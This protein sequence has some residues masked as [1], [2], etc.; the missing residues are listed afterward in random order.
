MDFEKMLDFKGAGKWTLLAATYFLLS[1]GFLF[2]RW[3]FYYG[4]LYAVAFASIAIVL[5]DP[6]PRLIESLCAAAAG[7]LSVI[8]SGYANVEAVQGMLVL[9]FILFAFMFMDD[10]MMLTKPSRN[11]KY[12]A[13]AAMLA[14]GFWAFDYFRLRLTSGAPLPLATILNHGGVML[15]SLNEA[16]KMAGAKYEYQEEVS[17]VS[18]AAAIIGAILLVVVEGWGLAIM[19]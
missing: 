1:L 16:L 8:A 10:Q 7:V 13:V 18:V 2:G 6:K 17:V 14:M 19:P 12:L 15:L 9:D 4:M 3:E 11:L 5:S